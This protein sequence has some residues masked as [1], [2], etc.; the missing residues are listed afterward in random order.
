[1]LKQFLSSKEI[2]TTTWKELY[3]VVRDT[4]VLFVREKSFYHGASLAYFTIV[5]LVPILYLSIATFG[6][7]IGQE[8]MI[9]V[10]SF[11]LK[12][13]VG[14][15]DISGLVSFM[16]TLNFEKSNRLMRIIGIVSLIVTSTTL[17][18]SLKHSI[19][20]LYGIVPPVFRGKKQFFKTILERGINFLFL[21][22]FGLLVIL[23]YFGE[24]FFIS[25]GKEFLNEGSTLSWLFR[26]FVQ[27]G[28]VILSNIAMFYLI[29]K[30]LHN[31]YVPWKLALAGSTVTALFFYMGH[32]LIKMYVTNYFFAKDTGIAGSILMLLVFVYYTSQIIFIGVKLTAVYA[33]KVGYTIRVREVK[34]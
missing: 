27:N 30:Y 14:F 1:M 12:D 2:R 22:V 10:I 33:K 15:E 25:F 26:G 34:R 17:F 31:G 23:T 3:E 16:D 18:A 13:Q 5:A 29:F 24:L 20:E 9:S 7:I 4:F 11:L 32:L 8:K 28:I 19:N 21:A 6:Q